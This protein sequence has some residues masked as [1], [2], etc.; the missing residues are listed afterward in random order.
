VPQ[1][2]LDVCILKA[3]AAR[4]SHAEVGALTCVALELA[5]GPAHRLDLCRRASVPPDMLDRIDGWLQVSDGMVTGLLVPGLEP[6]RPRGPRQGQLFDDATVAPVPVSSRNPGS[7]RAATIA[8]GVR[9]LGRA[10]IGEQNARSFLGQQLKHSGFG[11]L[12]EAI[13]AIEPKLDKIADPRSWIAAYVQN[14]AAGTSKAASDPR[15][16][17]ETSRNRSTGARASPAEKVRPLATPEFLGISPARVRLIEETNR[18]LREEQ[19][20]L[21]GH[22]SQADGMTTTRGAPR[23]LRRAAPHG[24]SETFGGERYVGPSERRDLTCPESST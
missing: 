13:D 19:E 11:V 12:A 24:R 20:R 15:T 4:L 5:R 7:L 6:R 2:D 14:H 18:Q 16:G 1:P 22:L 23:P 3:A 21:F 17:S 8:S 9:V 10:G